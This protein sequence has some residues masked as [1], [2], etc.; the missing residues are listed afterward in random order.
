MDRSSSLT[1]RY[2]LRAAYD[3]TR[4]LG[5]QSQ[6]EKGSLQDLL[7]EALHTC[8]RDPHIHPVASGRTD[9][10]VHALG[11]IIHFDTYKETIDTEKLLRSLN[12]LLPVEFR[13][14]ALEKSEPDFH[15]RYSACGKIYHYYLQTTPL[16]SP[17]TRLYRWH[18]HQKLDFE[19]L[20]QACQKLVGRHDFKALA[21]ENHK[22]VAAH[23]SIRTLSRVEPHF[24]QGSLR[25]E[26]EGDG[27][28]Y[29]MVR[30]CVGLITEVARGYRPI[31]DID[32]ILRSQKRPQAGYCAPA[33]G[34]FLYK[35]LYEPKWET[36][37]VLKT[38][39]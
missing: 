2:R 31:E 23:D 30:N 39:E 18:I 27:F 35:V 1:Y 13:I 8:L 7:K 11:Q 34:L 6:H 19:L 36:S 24:L 14:L 17:F 37:G 32:L 25:L 26:F 20:K 12:G 38:E 15:A 21:N 10:G 28:L 9:A 5:W 33:H 22:G 29:K 3:G 4:F 16:A